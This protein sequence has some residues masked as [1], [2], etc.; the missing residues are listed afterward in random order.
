MASE[1]RLA[2]AVGAALQA[3]GIAVAPGRAERLAAALAP[4]IEA[5]ARDQAEQVPDF[6]AVMEAERWQA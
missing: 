4:L 2:A 6:P 5:S 3:Q 1:E